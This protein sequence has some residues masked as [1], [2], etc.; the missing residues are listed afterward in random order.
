MNI[1]QKLGLRKTMVQ[2]L[3]GDNVYCPICAGSFITFLPFGRVKR[4][5]AQCPQCD[6]LE[7]HRLQFLF[8]K[9]DT[10]LFDGSPKKLLHVAPE[11]VF[12][13]A[14][15]T[16]PGIDYYPIDKFMEGYDYPPGTIDMDILYL[17]YADNTFD[18]IICN[19]V[20]EHIP[21][22]KA[23]M[24]E[25]F[26]VLK[27]GGVALLQVPLDKNRAVTYE[28][29]AITDPQE[30]I[31]H[32]GQFDHV[33]FYGLDYKDRLSA[34]GFTVA[35]IDCISRLCDNAVFHYGLMPGEDIYKCQK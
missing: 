23:A 3:E 9:S 34:A 30:R 32:F 7:R 6:S 4:A 12:F 24:R 14:F 20:L 27:P 10:N 22:D 26:R 18:A 8:L 11:Q 1:L 5:N 15:S 2:Y 33:R 28:D 17:G 25:L 29:L 35:V 19:H 13:R 21:D 16:A 31:K